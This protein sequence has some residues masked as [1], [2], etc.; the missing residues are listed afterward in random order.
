MTKQKF[1]TT[2]MAFAVVVFIVFA[3]LFVD[4]GITATLAYIQQYSFFTIPSLLVTWLAYTVYE[5]RWHAN[6]LKEER[7]Q[8]RLLRKLKKEQ[9]AK[10]DTQ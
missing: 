9:E 2:I 6:K 7:A 1:K 3:A 8:K 5:G 4:Y 10:N